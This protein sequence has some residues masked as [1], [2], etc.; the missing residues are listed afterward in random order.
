MACAALEP[1]ADRLAFL[2]A[3]FDL[4]YVAAADSLNTSC[5]NKPLQ[6]LCHSCPADA[7]MSGECCPA[8]ERPGV[9]QRLAIAGKLERIARFLRNG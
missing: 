5:P 4:E 9:E 2:H 6:H 7:K 8:L 3:L 1:V